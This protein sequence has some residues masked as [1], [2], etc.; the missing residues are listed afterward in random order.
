LVFKM[1]AYHDS[2]LHDLADR[3]D[4]WGVTAPQRFPGWIDPAEMTAL[5]ALSGTEY[6]VRWL[7]LMIEHHEGA[8]TLAAVEASE[9]ADEELRAL[10]RRIADTQR[11]EIAKMKDILDSLTEG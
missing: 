1:S 8:V 2:E 4:A 5:S 6:D 9:S 3:V 7:D 10:A 11:G